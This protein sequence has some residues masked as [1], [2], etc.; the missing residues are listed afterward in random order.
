M[1]TLAARLFVGLLVVGSGSVPAQSPAV[2]ARTT[3][4][5]ITPARIPERIPAQ[6]PVTPAGPRLRPPDSATEIVEAPAV[7]PRR[8]RI[9]DKPRLMSIPHAPEL[10]A[11]W[12]PLNSQVE[13]FGIDAQGAIKGMWKR[14]V[15]F[16]EASFNLSGPGAAPPGAPL[17][18]VWQPL[19]EQLEVFT[20]NPNGQLVVAW[21]AHNGRWLGPV[22]ISRANFARP[23]AHVTAVFQ[24]VNNQLEVFAIDATGAVRLAWKAQNGTWQDSVALTPP[25]TAPAGAPITAVWQ[26]LNE[27]LEVFWIG[28]DGALR[29]VWK[30]HN[31]RWQPPFTLTPAG[32]TNPRAKI[33]AVWQPLN[34]QLEL[35][36]VDK[37][38]GINVIWKAHNGRWFAPY[39]L[40]G[41]GI[42][43]AGADIVAAFDSL[44]GRMQVVTMGLRGE[45]IHAWK[46]N[47]GAWKPGPPGAFSAKFVDPG[48]SGSWPWGAS[49]ASVVQP[50]PDS[51][52][53]FVFTID[54]TQAV[55]A[56]RSDGINASRPLQPISRANFGPIY[57]THAAYCSGVLRQWS[58]GYDPGDEVLQGCIDYMGIT[59]Y[60]DRQ[61][62]GIGIGYPPQAESPRY[63][64][65]QSRAHSEDVIEQAEHIIRGVAEGLKDAAVAT[66][67]YSPEIVQGAACMNGVV[68]ACASLAVDLAARA[69]ELP[70]EIKDAVD[71]ATDASGCV[72]GDVVS[73]AK[74]GA[75]GARAVGIGIPGEE[76][77]QIAALIQ[78]CAN[79]D[80]GACLR[81]GEKAAMAAGVPLQQINQAALNAQDCYAGGVDACIALGR[82]AAK[83]GIPVGGVADGAANMQQCSYGSLADCQQLGQALAAVPR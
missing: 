10:A 32:F 37:A 5:V 64:Q 19:N 81:L 52:H 76:A 63:L 27:Q 3:P 31:G 36:A 62:A 34:E 48:P 16:W 68:F 71:L 78:A 15:F 4:T 57:G 24:P 23:G 61:G 12:Q 28:N 35:F 49:L 6:T 72:N 25:G 40:G 17:A 55:T 83:A 18:A 39:V 73:C 20:V 51:D 82:Q 11:V 22:A 26:P 2:R 65:C 56:L 66:I 13:V 46:M 69:I 67:V 43:R 79:E 38:G 42:A 74:L 21:K 33:A 1:K 50:I 30:Q 44:T 8:D 9:T 14:E 80:Y 45:L 54:D 59:A 53:F 75:A 47:N 58:N 60:C 41:P 77:G 7:D 29:G 70:P